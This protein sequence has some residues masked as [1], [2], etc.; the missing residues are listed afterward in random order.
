MM[1]VRITYPYLRTDAGDTSDSATP[2]DPGC[3]SDQFCNEISE[4]CVS[5]DLTWII[6]QGGTF[7]MGSVYLINR[8][9]QPVHEVSVPT[10]EITQ[11]EIT[12]GQYAQCVED[13]VCT[14]PAASVDNSN[15]YVAEREYHPVHEVSLSQAE[16]FCNWVGG[17]LPSEAEWE[18]AARSEGQDIDY[19]WGNETATCDYCV[20]LS[21]EGYSCGIGSYT[22][23][24]CSKPAGNTEQGLCDM[25]GNV[26]EWTLDNWH[27]SYDPDSDGDVDA[28]LDGSAWIDEPPSSYYTAKGGD[29]VNDDYHQ[30]TRFRGWFLNTA[31]ATNIGFRCA[32]RA[33]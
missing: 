27:A 28:P 14:E 20:M 25:A 18:Y 23:E 7:Q 33:F 31:Q 30:R 10:F 22:W 21:E 19:P 15:W 11:T 17:R 12:V 2:C 24:V 3:D 13:N 4:V 1:M 26:G 8:D 5:L 29:W 9:E 6:I 32:R 16:A